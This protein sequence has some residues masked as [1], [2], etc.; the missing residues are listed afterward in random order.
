MQI[1]VPSFLGLLWRVPVASPRAWLM[2]RLM[3]F[4][5]VLQTIKWF[6][7]AA[8]SLRAVSMVRMEVTYF[9]FLKR[10]EQ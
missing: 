4:L 8:Q 10:Q 1:T 2:Q 6:V 7:H 9:R 3:D 5:L